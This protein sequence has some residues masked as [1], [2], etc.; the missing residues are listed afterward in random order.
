MSF[1]ERVA[2]SGGGGCFGG[3]FVIFLIILIIII[4]LPLFGSGSCGGFGGVAHE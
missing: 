1:D 4:L 2:V 3:S